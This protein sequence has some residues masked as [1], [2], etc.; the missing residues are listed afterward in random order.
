[1]NCSR[2]AAI[3]LTLQVTSL[4]LFCAPGASAAGGDEH[5][6]RQFGWPGTSN[7][8]NALAIHS[9]LVYASGYP[10]TLLFPSNNFIEVWDGTRWSYLPGLTGNTLII[11]DL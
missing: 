7:V 11:Y 6:D 5:W 3:S 8:V 9:G 10:S 1:M 4:L 2:L